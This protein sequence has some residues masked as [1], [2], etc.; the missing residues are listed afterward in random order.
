MYIK[1]IRFGYIKKIKKTLVRKLTRTKVFDKNVSQGCNLT[2]RLE[3]NIKLFH[4]T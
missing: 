1:V 2:K 3:H 4:H